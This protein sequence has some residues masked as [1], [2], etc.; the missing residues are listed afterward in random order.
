MENKV[1][2]LKG[3][4]PE[5]FKRAMALCGLREITS[6][7]AMVNG[8]AGNL[9]TNTGELTVSDDS[10]EEMACLI[11]TLTNTEPEKPSEEV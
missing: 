5:K 2:D 10:S 11:R 9:N 8:E 4:N 3:V 6:F 1:I 7:E